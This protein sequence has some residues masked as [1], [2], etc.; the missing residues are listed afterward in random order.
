MSTEMNMRRKIFL[1]IT[2]ACMTAIFLFSSRTGEESTGDSYF[3]GNVV[4]EIFVPGFDEWSAQEQLE[5]AGKIDHPVR[6]TA[7][8]MEYAVLGLL[9]AGAFIGSRTSILAG[10]LIPWCIASAYAATDEIHQLFVPGRSG[11]VS[12]VLLDSAGVLAGLLVLAGGRL[13]RQRQREAAGGVHV[14]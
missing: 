8:A 4:G 6:K 10:I 2:I 9:T 5:F 13:L 12:D 3:V 14:E 1:V 7:H 11:Q